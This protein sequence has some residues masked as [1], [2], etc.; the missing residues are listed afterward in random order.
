MTLGEI[1]S[2]VTSGGTPLATRADYYGGN[3]PWLR[4]QE[5]RFTDILDTEVKIT[6]KGLKSSSAKW[7]PGN[8][9]IVAISGATAARSAINKIPLTTNQHCCN[10]EI[11]PAQASYR[12]VFH[13]VSKEYENLKALGQGARADLNSGIIKNFPI[14]VPPMEEQERIVSILD[15][16]DVLVNDLSSGLPAEIEARR[17][18]YE[19]YRDRLLAFQ[20]AA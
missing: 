17:R 4:T 19:Y 12:Y 2:R 13:W 14:P 5:V 9:V 10:L 15:K 6:E 7:I 8:C 18:Q 11:D 3:I 16:F 20:E 1:S